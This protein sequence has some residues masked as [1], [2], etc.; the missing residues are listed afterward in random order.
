MG[1]F[2]TTERRGDVTLVN[3]N[4]KKYKHKGKS[5]N[6]IVMCEKVFFNGELANPIVPWW[7]KLFKNN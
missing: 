6:T 4:G 1:I 3:V 5:C 2:T 7:K